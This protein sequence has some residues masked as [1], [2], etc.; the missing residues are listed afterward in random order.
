MARRRCTL[1]L[2]VV[3]AAFTAPQY[4]AAAAT[5]DGVLAP[6][7]TTTTLYDRVAGPLRQKRAHVRACWRGSL[8]ALRDFL[9]PEHRDTPIGVEEGT[10]QQPD[11]DA[12]GFALRLHVRERLLEAAD[13]SGLT[14]FYAEHP[15]VTRYAAAAAI[16][17]ALL[18]VMSLVQLAAGLCAR[19][20]MRLAFR[21][22]G[23]PLHL[24]EAD[25]LARER[26]RAAAA[27]GASA[28]GGGPPRRA[29]KE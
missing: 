8:F 27:A 16:G 11:E 29:K 3:L 15:T 17:L 18:G 1:C 2:V 12:A 22:T 19:E 24:D 26:S 25:W 10:G 20:T 13:G 4:S 21:L 5:S 9:M 7:P 23:D 28:S 14:A 6:Q